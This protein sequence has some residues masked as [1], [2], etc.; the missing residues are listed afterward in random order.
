MLS[1]KTALFEDTLFAPSVSDSSLAAQES[2]TA[3]PY[4]VLARKYRPKKFSHMIGQ[5]AVVRVLTQAL[6]QGRVG[7]GFIFSGIRGVGK[8]TSAR[9]LACA[10][11]CLDLQRQEDGLVEPCGIC[12]SCQAFSAD[13]H[14]DIVEMDAASHTGVDDIREILEGCRYR[15]VLGRFKVFIID[16]VHMLSKSAFNA[17]LK[18]LEEP[19]EHVKFIFA[20]T[21]LRKIP[22]TVLSRCLRFDLKRLDPETLVPYLAT[23]CEREEIAADPQALL[24]L[25]RAGGGSARDSLSLL[26]QAIVVAQQQGN[27]AQGHGIQFEDV[28]QMLGLL[29][30][31]RLSGLFEAV[32]QGE[33]DQ[34][35]RHAHGLYQD[36]LDPLMVLEELTHLVHQLSCLKAGAREILTGLGAEEKAFLDLWQDRVTL[37]QLGRLWQMLLKGAEELSRASFPQNAL[38][39]VL[40]R[41]AYVAP[42]PTPDQ[43]LPGGPS[44]A[45]PVSRAST[46]SVAASSPVVVVQE[47]PAAASAST[48]KTFQDVLKLVE[49]KREG[50]L[51]THLMQDVIVKS[52]EDKRITLTLQ[53]GAPKDLCKRL[54]S[55]LR[56]ETKDLWH[57][58]A[59]EGEGG[60]TLAVQKKAD[61]LARQKAVEAHSTIAQARDL[62]PGIVVESVRPF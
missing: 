5:E 12:A 13:Q 10:L 9:I 39:M 56:A 55:F 41:L 27:G 50:L 11:N 18:T 36:G 26:D 49:T 42:L 58:L 15:P 43:L 31:E 24:A 51:H 52:V 7:H 2:P 62:F 46:A 54:E 6:V 16:E 44:G 22:A 32:L 37:P 33:A 53:S 47:P 29:D 59:T 19:P 48:L 45:A 17:L 4:R 23:I 14:L 30:R 57:V 40:I 34:T 20:T 61:A 8:T 60:Q 1:E 25:A 3:S 35:L 28:R 21:E 38:E